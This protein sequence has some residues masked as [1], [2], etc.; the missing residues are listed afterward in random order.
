MVNREKCRKGV[1]NM[2]II[3]FILITTVLPAL[4]VAMKDEWESKK[5]Q[6]KIKEVEK[7]LN[8]VKNEFNA[9]KEQL[10]KNLLNNLISLMKNCVP[11]INHSYKA[12]KRTIL[13]TNEERLIYYEEIEN[14]ITETLNLTRLS[15]IRDIINKKQYKSD[16][17]YKIRVYDDEKIF[18]KDLEYF[19]DNRNFFNDLVDLTNQQ[20]QDILMDYL[21][22][23]RGIDG[24]AYVNR[25]L[26]DYYDVINLENIRLEIEDKQGNIQ[27]IENDN[28]LITRQGI[29]ILEVKNYGSSGSYDLVIE[30]DGR[31]LKRFPNGKLE[32]ISNAT[33]QNNRHVN[34]VSK[35]INDYLQQDSSIPVYG[36]VIIPNDSISIDNR[37]PLQDIY[38]ASQIYQFIMSKDVVLSQDEMEQIETL[39]KSRNLPPKSYPLID[40]VDFFIGNVKFI[41]QQAEKY[42][43]WVNKSIELINNYDNERDDLEGAYGIKYNTLLNEYPYYLVCDYEEMLLSQ[44]QLN[45]IK[46]SVLGRESL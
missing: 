35:L 20:Y 7:R 13:V 18:Q 30:R 33:G 14:K 22:T 21:A 37:D 41:Q 8:E 36:V 26:N 1:C 31:W 10:T 40:Q 3:I 11:V 43:I 4:L 19:E 44:R 17:E 27:S 29:F 9:E 16:G 23:K 28:I 32:A 38:R 5:M 24:E 34:Y 45:L 2:Y 15:D 42:E 39:I 25:V 12:E 46:Q 6:K